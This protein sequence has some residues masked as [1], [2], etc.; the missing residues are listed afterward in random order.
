MEACIKEDVSY[1]EN[2]DVVGTACEGWKRT[3]GV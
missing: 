2:V 3:S 1:P